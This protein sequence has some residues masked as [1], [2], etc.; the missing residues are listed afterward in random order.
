MKKSFSRSSAF[1]GLSLAGLLF[2]TTV[3]TSLAAPLPPG[4]QIPAPYEPEPIGGIQLNQVSAPYANADIQGTL[5]STV[6]ANDLS[7]PFGGLT[8][9]Y[10]VLVSPNSLAAVTGFTVGN[11]GGFLTDA[12]YGDAFAGGGGNIAIIA[13]VPPNTVDRSLPPGN[14]IGYDFFPGILPGQGSA[15][16]VVQTDAQQWLPSLASVIDATA[17]TVPSLAPT[18]VP[19][20]VTFAL[21]GMGIL[22]LTLIRKRR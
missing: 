19:E 12:S 1:G 10:E 18:P 5:I 3:A 2:A 6:I 21:V 16:L 8:F 9:T 4:V 15:L 14:V 13:G 7:N 20:P 22:G 11:Y 17:A